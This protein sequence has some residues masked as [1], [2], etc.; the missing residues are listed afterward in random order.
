MILK[1]KDKKLI[2]VDATFIDELSGLAIVKILNK[3]THSTMMIKL[4]LIQNLSMLDITNN[5]FDTIY[6]IQRRY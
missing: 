6:L 5:G 1:P 3:T 4:K 2:K